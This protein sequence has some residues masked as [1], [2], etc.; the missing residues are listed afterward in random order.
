MKLQRTGPSI[1]PPSPSSKKKRRRRRRRGKR[2]QQ[3]NCRWSY[4]TEQTTTFNTTQ[5]LTTTTT[6]ATRHL[7]PKNVQDRWHWF[8]CYGA[9]LFDNHQQSTINPINHYHY[10]YYYYYYY[11]FPLS[12]K[13]GRKA[14]HFDHYQLSVI[15]TF[16]ISIIYHDIHRSSIHHQIY[17]NYYFY[18][19][20][21]RHTYLG[22]SE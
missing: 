5:L 11:S 7:L 14:I 2:R 18:L 17:M 6:T 19:L 22:S 8:Y 20:S 1:F 13:R 16:I 21:E 15:I 3:S 9:L 4:T 12:A 10:H